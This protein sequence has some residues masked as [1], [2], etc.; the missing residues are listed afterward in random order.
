MSTPAGPPPV[1]IVDAV[2]HGRLEAALEGTLAGF[3]E[4]VVRRGRI[5][6]IHTEVL[7]GFECRGI[8]ARLVRWALDDARRRGRLVIA[9]CPYVRAYLEKHPEDHDIVVGLRGGTGG[10][11]GDDPPQHPS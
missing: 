11:A 9:T 7:P 6:L 2:D 4:Y 10:P 5:A 8:A 3:L 1:E